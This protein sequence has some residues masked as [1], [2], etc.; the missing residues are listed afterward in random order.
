MQVSDVLDKVLIFSPSYYL[1]EKSFQ[2]TLLFC[3]FLCALQR[4]CLFANWKCM[5]TC[6]KQIYQH[7]FPHSICSCLCHILVILPIFHLFILLLY[8]LWGSVINDL[9]CYY[10]NYFGLLPTTLI[11]DDKTLSIK[12]SDNRILTAPPTG[13]FSISLLSFSLPIL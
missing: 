11:Q 4:S 7:H 2:T 5:A 13:W 8:F 3:A 10:Y 9:W 6:M 1:L 12:C